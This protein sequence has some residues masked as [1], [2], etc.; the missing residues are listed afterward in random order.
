MSIRLAESPNLE[1]QR[2]DVIFACNFGHNIL[3][4]TVHK[5]S[6]NMTKMVCKYYISVAV[7]RCLPGGGE[8]F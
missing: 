4:A 7:S 2:L 3:S 5:M 6:A 1:C 8:F